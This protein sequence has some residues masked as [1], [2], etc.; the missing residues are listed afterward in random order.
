MS[1]FY[2]GV[3]AGVLPPVVPITFVTDD[4]TTAT[5]AAN[6]LNVFTPGNGTDGI[7]TSA[8]GNTILITLTEA[9]AE[10][11]N[12]TSGMSPYTVTA[13]DYYISC[14]STT[15]PITINL[16]DAPAANR[17]FIIKDRTGQSAV[18]A[19]TIKSLTSASTIDQA[20]SYVF[21]DNFE[22]LEL[23]YHSSNYESF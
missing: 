22:S 20:A 6:I 5:A 17:Q 16:P 7:A 13:T 3:T 10:Y 4:A 9:A 21:S 14:D 1:Q 19:I 23:L 12:V 2:Q 18:N 15:G 11:I 8:S